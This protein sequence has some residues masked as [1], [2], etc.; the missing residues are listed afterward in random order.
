MLAGVDC[1]LSEPPVRVA[2]GDCKL[3]DTR[4]EVAWADCK[5]SDTRCKVAWADCK[6][7]DTWCEGREEIA[8]CQTPDARSHG[9]IVNR[10][11]PPVSL[12]RD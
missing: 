9:V 3:S 11:S 12:P 4:C 6:P 10:L 7:S 5:P 1:K 8:N 2:W